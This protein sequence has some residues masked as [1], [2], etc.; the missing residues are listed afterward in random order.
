LPSACDDFSGAINVYIFNER[1]GQMSYFLRFLGW[2]ILYS[3]FF[4]I[5][6][7]IMVVGPEG[8]PLA[9]NLTLA[10]LS[11]PV[12]YFTWSA[13]DK[14]FGAPKIQL[15]G[16]AGEYSFALRN[17]A[18]NYYLLTLKLFLLAMGANGIITLSHHQ[19]GAR[20]FYIINFILLYSYAIPFFIIKTRKLI[21]AKASKIIV[22]EDKLSLQTDGRVVTAIAF[23]TIDTISIDEDAFA[24]LIESSGS[25]LYI[26]GQKA[27]GTA[28]FVVGA[29]KINDILKQK[30]GNKFKKVASMKAE[31]KRLNFRPAV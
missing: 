19:G 25:K 28:F 10:V 7:D 5:A 2:L 21:K 26:C 31:L 3:L 20:I 11:I 15:S 4:F 6:A 8:V 18:L 13:F 23:N 17:S 9:L 16:S 1:C 22:D 27:K 29:D 24:L 12:W 30:A 14:S